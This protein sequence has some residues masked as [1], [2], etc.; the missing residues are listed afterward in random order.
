MDSV[1]KCGNSKFMKYVMA[2]PFQVYLAQSQY[3]LIFST[4]RL[5][6]MGDAGGPKT[7]GH[8]MSALTKTQTTFEASDQL[9]VETPAHLDFKEPSHHL[10]DPGFLS[11]EQTPY[12]A[13]GA[14]A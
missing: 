7:I 5:L 9:D 11:A 12:P 2:E 3:T 1:W 6:Q 14:V 13:S 10:F 8:F 4:P